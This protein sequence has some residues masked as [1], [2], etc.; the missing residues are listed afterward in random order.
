MRTGGQQGHSRWCGN[1]ACACPTVQGQGA[2]AAALS[3]AD[4]APSWEVLEGMVKVRRLAAAAAAATLPHMQATTHAGHSSCT[5][6]PGLPSSWLGAGR[7]NSLLGILA[8]AA[9][10]LSLVLP[11]QLVQ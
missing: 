1:G 9:P 6:Q 3:F 4:N 5:Q 2:S 7:W 10:C 11:V 8:A